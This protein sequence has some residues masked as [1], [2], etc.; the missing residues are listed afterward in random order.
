M[1]RTDLERARSAEIQSHRARLT[2]P[3]GSSADCT[4]ATKRLKIGDE[5]ALVGWMG[6]E[7]RVAGDKTQDR[8]EAAQPDFGQQLQDSAAAPKAAS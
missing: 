4:L 2:L 5:A 8:S 6:S 3:A 1:N 7:S